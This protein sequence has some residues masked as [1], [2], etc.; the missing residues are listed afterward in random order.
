MES[1]ERHRIE[2]GQS[3]EVRTRMM[4]SA[5]LEVVPGARER[6]EDELQALDERSSSFLALMEQ[7]MPRAG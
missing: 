7:A 1:E 3:V 2:Q 6:Y 5:L 4:I